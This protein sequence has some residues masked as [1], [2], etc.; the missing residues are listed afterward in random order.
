MAY[1]RAVRAFL[2]WCEGCGLALEDIEP[3]I[4]AA[5]IEQ[6]PSSAP[7][8]KQHLA[9]IRL[10]FDWLVIGQIVSFNPASSVRGPKHVVKM[11][12]TPVLAAPE[13]RQ[14]FE[15]MD[16][17]KVVGLRDRALIGLMV[18]SFARVSA[19]IAMQ[20]RDYYHQGKRSY[21]RFAREGWQ[22]QR[23]AGVPQGPGV[24]GYLPGDIWYR[25]T[26]R[27]RRCFAPAVAAGTETGSLNRV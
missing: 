22:V 10:L 14:I 20:I 18:F 12:K 16:L 6:H 4:L 2:A 23:G 25:G 19:T 15:A 5:Y 11:G 9:A 3:M 8:V 24:T 21:F 1:F 27:K 17:S 26:Q 7:T 13:V